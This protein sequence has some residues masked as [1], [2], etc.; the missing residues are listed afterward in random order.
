MLKI[1]KHYFKSVITAL[2]GW[3]TRF[4]VVFDQLYLQKWSKWTLLLGL[5]KIV[6][7]PDPK[8]VR[9]TVYC[10]YSTLSTYTLYYL[11]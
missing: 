3:F 9:T 1:A 11:Y 8:E 6:F 7:L 4:L 10:M 2:N 5:I